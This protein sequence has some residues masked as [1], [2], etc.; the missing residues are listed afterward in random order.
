MMLVVGLE[1]GAVG[2]YMTDYLA[3]IFIFSDY[4]VL[5]DRIMPEY[6]ILLQALG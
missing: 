5:F 6:A 4:G 3:H 2:I 1:F